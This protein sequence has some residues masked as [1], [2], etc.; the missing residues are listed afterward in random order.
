M[1]AAARQ[2]VRDVAA[3]RA[4]SVAALLSIVEQIIE[5]RSNPDYDRRVAIRGLRSFPP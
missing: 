2:C 5:F 4:W 1:L 3:P